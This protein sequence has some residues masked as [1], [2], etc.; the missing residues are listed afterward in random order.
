V[1]PGIASE[2][3]NPDC[4]N[5][6]FYTGGMGRFADF[7]AR[8]DVV[9]GQIKDFTA[10]EQA[11]LERQGIK[12]IICVPI[13]VE[14]YWWGCIGFNECLE[15]REWAIVEIKAL[16]TAANMLGA[17]IL[18]SQSEK[19]LRESE[20]RL[21]SLSYQLLDVQ[22]N[23]RKRL[24]LELHDVLGHDPLNLKLKIETFMDELLPQHDHFRGEVAKIVYALQD[25]LKI[26]RLLYQDLIPADLEEQGLTAALENLLEEFALA[27]GI[28]WEARL[29]RT[30]DNLFDLP[31]Q[32]NIYRLVQEGLTNIGKHAK[33]THIF[34]GAEKD[35][36]KLTLILEDNGIGFNVS[37]VRAQKR[38]MGLLSME[39]RLETWGGSFGIQSQ[40]KQGTRICATIPIFKRK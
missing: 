40:P 2:M 38:T 9:H 15:E 16:K 34:L 4:Q 29:D 26:V 22:E 25:S 20:K 6:P 39:K 24:A 32:T 1:A 14:D 17:A 11:V 10:E 23:E 19:A 36:E 30:I 37:E 27:R 18:Q 21:R 28:T 8:G 3:D 12:S 31:L 5:F 35:K 33:A 7:M 13:F